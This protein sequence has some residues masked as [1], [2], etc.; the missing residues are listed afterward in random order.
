M[1][2]APR[3]AHLAPLLGG[4][5]LGGCLLGPAAGDGAA[6]TYDAI[7]ADFDA[8]YGLFG[9]KPDVD[10]D[11][12]G[13]SCRALLPADDANGAALFDA[14]KC[15]LGPLEDNHVRVLRPG[16]DDGMWTPGRLEDLE[17]TDFSEEASASWVPDLTDGPLVRWGWLDSDLTGASDLGYLHVRTVNPNATVDA[18]DAAMEQLSSADG[19]I[20]DLRENGGGFA[21]VLEP[22]ASHFSDEGYVYSRT[23][24]REG[25]GRTDYGEW[26]DYRVDAGE[27]P[28]TRPF[29]VLTH[30]S[31]VSGAELLTLALRERPQVTHVGSTTSGAMAAAVW[32]DAPNGWAYAVSVEDARSAD[33]T[34]YEGIGVV[35]DIE[36]QSTLEETQAGVDRAIE[37]AVEVL[38]GAP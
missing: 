14:L 19:L 13:E 23:R 10:W 27:A 28:F 21:V 38:R 8:H 5:L 17:V 9:V 26:I 12:L 16:V 22:V 31:T 2:A 4:C 18:V 34:S 33:L 25:E 24:R 6:A 7:W 35:P 32:R 11:A 36:A 37:A 29:V 1:I 3:L 15:L 20:V 30:A